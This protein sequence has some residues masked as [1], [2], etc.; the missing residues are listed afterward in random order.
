MGNTKP[1]MV[2]VIG[3]DG[4]PLGPAAREALQEAT[5]VVGGVRHLDAVGAPPWARRIF[6]GDLNVAL[7]RLA[8]HDG[9]AVVVA[10]GDPGFFGIVRTLREAGIRVV[11]IP[12]VSSVAHA[13]SRVGMTW[14]DAMVVSVHGRVDPT[15]GDALLEPGRDLRTAI[16]VCRAHPKVA[17]LTGPGAGPREIAVGLCELGK[18]T[19]DPR[20]VVERSMIV[21]QH[22]GE[23]DEAVEWLTLEEAATRHT[24]G[25]PNVVL[26]IDERRLT[27]PRRWTSSWTPP[28]N[29]WALPENAFVHRGGMISKTE[30]RALVLARLAPSPGSLIWDVGAGSGAIGIECARLGAAVIAIERDPD[31]AERVDLNAIMH[32]V[33]IQLVR[34][35]APDV[36]LNLPRPDAVFIGGGGTDVVRHCVNRDPRIVVVALATVDRVPA[37][38]KALKAGGRKVDGV[39][40]HASRLAA[41]PGDA[42]RFAATNPVF[43]LWGERS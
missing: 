15:A 34:G 28:P 1:P 31:A 33:D 23:D 37:V 39:L 42:H 17:I 7:T 2:T 12:S 29:G 11:T 14:D 27:S 13:F 36:L 10:S 19:S 18:G 4:S 16:N 3:Y 30:V 5:L 43:V 32:G 25:E 38:K 40:L 41:V 9:P 20:P 21:A 24:W 26:V 22:L 6:L 8:V 35:Q